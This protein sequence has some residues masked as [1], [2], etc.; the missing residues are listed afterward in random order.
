MHPLTDNAAIT[1]QQGLQGYWLG[2]LREHL[3]DLAKRSPWYQR[4]GIEGAELNSWEH[5]S[6]LPFTTKDQLAQHNAHFLAVAKNRIVDHVFTSGST[7]EPVPF[8]LSEPDLQRLAT[9]EALSLATAGI[10]SDDVVQIT[11]TLDKRF[12]AGMAYWLGLR[13]IGAGVVRSGPGHALGQWDTA[14]RCGTTTLI[15]VPSFLLRMLQEWKQTGL[16]PRSIGLRKVICIG[17]PISDGNGGPNLL[18]KR[19]LELCDLQL[20][21]TYASTEMAT[22][23]TEP[24]PFGGHRVPHALIL[25]E[26]LDDNDRPV[27]EGS[28]GEVVA[29]PFDVEAMPLLRYRTGDICTW[30]GGHD[31]KG[32]YAMM[33]GPV[34]GRKEQRMKVKGTTLYPQQVIDAL[35]GEAAVRRFVV[36]REKDENGLDAVRVLVDADASTLPGLS[37]RLRDRLRVLP[38]VEVAERARIERLILD[39]HKRKPTLFIG[40]TPNN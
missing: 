19:I 13:Q 7:G 35:N 31:A 26:V 8:V 10:T 39:P 30:Q 4:A 34:L 12:M 25:V 24:V 32:R 1:D 29:T 23:F 20:H 21:G 33:L 40:D 22:A 17:E 28:V 6:K 14:V 3:A 36:L 2:R 15:A 38:L 27:P 9:N 5:V 11:T 18:A 37:E 16:D